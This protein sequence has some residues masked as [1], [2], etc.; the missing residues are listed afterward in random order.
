MEALWPGEGWGKGEAA[1]TPTFE[2]C[3]ISAAL[4][5]IYPEPC[6]FMQPSSLVPN[7]NERL[8][9]APSPPPRGVFRLLV[10]TVLCPS[11]G[12]VFSFPRIYFGF[13]FLLEASIT[14]ARFGAT[15]SLRAGAGESRMYIV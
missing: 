4:V 1:Y 3:C 2:F 7:V 9:F 13:N 10:K 12:G 14:R 6:H 8:L 5:Y 11:Q 15:A